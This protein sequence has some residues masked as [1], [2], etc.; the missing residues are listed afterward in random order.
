MKKI[1]RVVLA[2]LVLTAVGVGGYWYYRSKTASAAT[3]ASSTT[4]SEVV[5]VTQGSMSA[6]A[7]VV[8][9]V[10]AQQSSSLTFEHMSGTTNLLTLAVQAGNVVTA[11]QVLATID[12]AAYQQVLDQAKSD[13]QAAEERWQT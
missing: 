10:E 3:T 4:Y 12:S 13:L 7:S 8:G 2:V 1:I 9:Q 11:G 6:T 5:Q